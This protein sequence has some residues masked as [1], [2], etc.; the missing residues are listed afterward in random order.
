MAGPN[1]HDDNRAPRRAAVLAAGSA[2]PGRKLAGPESMRDSDWTV[3]L[4][5]TDEAGSADSQGTVIVKAYPPG[6]DGEAARIWPEL[7]DDDTWEQGVQRAVAAWSLDSMWWLLGRALTTNASLERG[8][9]CWFGPAVPEYMIASGVG[10]DEYE[11]YRRNRG[12][13]MRSPVWS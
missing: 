9:Y 2:A 13:V 1:G 8:R 5:C 10:V 6:P 11:A 7:A 4:R 3:V 12:A